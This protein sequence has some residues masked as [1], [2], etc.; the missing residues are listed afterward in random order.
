[1]CG[2]AGIVGSRAVNVSTVVYMTDLLAHR[3][4]DDSDIWKSDDGKT[5]LGHRRLSI[6]D[7][8]IGGHQPMERGQHVLT[9]N[10][11]IYNYL[12]LR[13]RLKGL[14]AEFSSQSD[15]EVL[16]KS[17]QI[18]GKECLKELNGMFAFALYDQRNHLL[19][20]ARDRFGE[21]PFL[22]VSGKNYFAFASEYKSLINLQGIS[23]KYDQTRLL[24]FLHDPSSGLD[25]SE[26][27]LFSGIHQLLPSH[28]L[29]L[30]ITSLNYNIDQYWKVEPT[31]E[32][33]NLTQA[34]A[35]LR[36]KEVLTDS[37]RLRMRSDVPLGSCLSGGLDSSSIVSIAKSMADPETPYV[38]FTGRF[39][40][41]T[42]DEWKWAEEIINL[43]QLRN[44]VTVP[45]ATNLLDELDRFVWHNELPVGGTSQYAQWC[46][47]KLAK[48][49]NVTVL[50]DGQGGDE[51][52]G[53]YE[54]YFNYYLESIAS[55]VTTQA[56]KDEISRIKQ[57]YPMALLSRKQKIQQRLPTRFRHKIAR[58]SGL[59]S[60]F[61]I[62]LKPNIIGEAHLNN[63]VSPVTDDRFHPLAAALW[64]DSLHTNLPVLLRYGDRNSMAHSR[65]VRLP[66]CDHRLVEL[67][68]SLSPEI[69]MGNIQTKRVLRG[70]MRDILPET[71]RK[72]WKKQGFL[73]P[74][75]L[76][77]RNGL[78]DHAQNII[79][80]DSFK[81]DGIWER[82]WWRSVLNRYDSGEFHLASTL[83]RPIIYDAWHRYF[84]NR[85]QQRQDLS[86]FQE[87][88]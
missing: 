23:R 40:G 42:A 75:D 58:L 13:E 19:F 21:K 74:Q 64:K 82:S 48:E 11:E 76:W 46:V 14:G 3:G 84:L 15:T 69:L 49:N 47:F 37:V 57:R 35:E 20:C 10:G 22:F 16:L 33:E 17:Y 38:S 86:I 70:S 1:M 79:E 39:P 45:T 68:L 31:S 41:S 28:S 83:W 88:S 43:H 2:I 8:S 7:T 36:F 5:V 4:P 9:Y 55:K 26:E 87:A 73:P 51:I 72:R 52:L 78:R 80:S 44:H 32:F 56:F 67:T 27:T 59:G 29:S 85:S 30:D 60:D 34:E 25:D 12:E 66:F 54:Q 62:G 18:W 24:S 77:F 81:T 6:I 50:L 71:I 53:G 63:P 65:E 61:L